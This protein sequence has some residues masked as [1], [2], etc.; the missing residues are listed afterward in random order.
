[1]KRL[2]ILL[3]SLVSSVAAFGQAGSLSQSGIFL[4]VN[5]T[6]TYQSSAAGKHAQGYRDI[7]FNNQATT[8]HFDIW[9]GSSYDHI[10]DFMSGSGS[11]GGG[12][13]LTWAAA[14]TGTTY[15]VTNA[16]NNKIIPFSNVS[17]VTVTLSNT[18]D[19]DVTVTFVRMEGAG[20]VTFAAGGTATLHS[21]GDE[22]TIESENSWVTWSKRTATEWHGTGVLG[23]DGGGNVIVP[24]QVACSDPVSALTTG[25]AK[26][27]FR[28]AGS[29]TVTGVKV[30]LLTAQSSGSVFTVDI[31]E[32]GTSILSTKLTV[33]NSEE[34]SVTAATP[35]VISDT[36]IAS[37]SEITI[38]FDQ[39]G[40]GGVGVVVTILGYY[41][42]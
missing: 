31:N 25:T 24:I 21:K 42:F 18:I 15:T 3:I 40:T 29:Y 11:G 39:V 10:F 17:G 26:G 20:E 36:S 1:M 35:A 12:S 5:D 2:L 16:D 34:T 38:D 28:I 4:R 33:D 13:D 23:P 22:V 8:K 27:Y 6:T 32:N 7:Y 14:E 37:D 30:S 41:N 9:N 19:S